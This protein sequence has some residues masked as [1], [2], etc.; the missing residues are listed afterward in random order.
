MES[1]NGLLFITVANPDEVKNKDTQRAIRRRVM[2]DIGRSRRKP[3][4]Q[5]AVTFIGQ[6]HQ[7][8]H[9]QKDFLC[10]ALE[11]SPLPI[12]LD[13]RARQL[14]HFM[15]SEADYRYRPFRG[16]WFE[17]ALR[18]GSAFKLSMA[19]AAMFLDEA[20]HPTT[21]KYERSAEA[22]AYY[23]ESVRQVTRRLADP[24]DRA[25]EG[26]MTAVLGLICHDL[27]VGTLDRWAYHIQ[28]L[29]HIIQLRN[30]FCGLNGNLQLFAS[31]FDVVGS[32]VK[33]TP[34]LTENPIILQDP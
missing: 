5:P 1:T 3:K 20:H 14:A 25:S 26:L 34:P 33:D 22:L 15:Q 10:P 32:V 21:F 13:N 16:I 8:D 11:S 18:D 23:G 19:N 29:K 9:N 6:P 24:I 31:W 27:Y 17:M 2:R 12:D 7:I 28:G 4:S 30:G